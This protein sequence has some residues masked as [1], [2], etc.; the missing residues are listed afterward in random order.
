ML[1]MMAPHYLIYIDFI[2]EQLVSNLLSKVLA[3]LLPHILEYK[4]TW[5]IKR[6]MNFGG[7]LKR[8]VLGGNAKSKAEALSIFIIPLYIFI[9][10][11]HQNFLTLLTPTAHQKYKF[12]PPRIFL[13]QFSR[14][15]ITISLTYQGLFNLECLI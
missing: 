15:M 3:W 12:N 2:L 10:L 7:P 11:Y 13:L 14:I 1:Q 6:A 4:A 9:T 8:A 5:T